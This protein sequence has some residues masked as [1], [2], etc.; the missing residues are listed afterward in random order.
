MLIWGGRNTSG[1]LNDGAAY[2]LA[3]GTWEALVTNGVPAARYDHAAVWTGQEMLIFGGATSTGE[4]ASAA[5][6][7]P[8]SG[9]WQALSTSG[10]PQARALPGTVWSGT[11]LVVFGGRANGQAEAALQRLT[12]QPTWYFY[13]KL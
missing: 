3:T 1:A 10:S 11:E 7:D 8:V 12:P 13:R 5:N 6:Y 4:L 9:L 2:T